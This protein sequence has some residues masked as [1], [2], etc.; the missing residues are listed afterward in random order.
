MAEA[1]AEKLLGRLV[2]PSIGA[3][4]TGIGGWLTAGATGAFNPAVVSLLTLLGG[5]GG[6]V[7]V[8]LY[9]RY[10]G[11]LAS[12]RRVAAEREA[13]DGLRYSLATSNAAAR[14][15]A[16]RL[17][18][19]L[20]WIDRF[21]GDAGT[22]DRTLFPHAFGLRTPAP[23]WTAP[24]FDRCLLIAM[25]YPLL[26]IFIVWVVSGHVGSAEAA[27]GL[28]AGASGW[29]RGAATIGVGLLML[30]AARASE[31]ID[32]ELNSWMVVVWGS[33]LL[34]ICFINVK[35]FGTMMWVMAAPIAVF[36]FKEGGN[37]L[38][39]LLVV[40]VGMFAKALCLCFR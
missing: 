39:I 14:L 19:F 18:R 7:F 20:N 35:V 13:Y 29:E 22:A 31:A 32:R 15:Y 28:K 10:L 40:I 6:L 36:L 30:T 26:T 27:F 12:N 1:S 4:L 34:L 25:I 37:S 17:T 3:G 2:G 11:I 5:I 33:I 24:A 38:L 9:R 21:F 23:L 8:I 16:E